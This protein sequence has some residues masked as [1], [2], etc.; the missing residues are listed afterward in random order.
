MKKVVFGLLLVVSGFA[1]TAQT[2]Q[3]NWLVGG[4]IELNTAKDDT[5]I[6]F[7]P[8]AGYFFANNFA[9]G[10]LVSLDYVKLVNSKTTTF[11]IGPFARYYFGTT[12][13][14]PFAAADINFTSSKVKT[15][16]TSSSLNGTKWFLGAGLAGF[17][18]RNVAIEGTA[19][20]KHTA[21]KD[22]DGTGGFNLR[23]GFQVYL[24]SAQ[25]ESIKT[26]TQ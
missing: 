12:N 1:A 5:R 6:N 17:I 8:S 19:G 15:S 10:A 21:I 26:I 2:E 7:S 9:A 11:G 20:Y 16:T 4:N 18:N 3:G 22:Q 23:I 14:R 24:S 13:I 25:V